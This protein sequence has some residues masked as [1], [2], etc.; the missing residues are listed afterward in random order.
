MKKSARA[1]FLVFL[2]SCGALALPQTGF[3]QEEG[4]RATLRERIKE[5]WLK[6]QQ[7]KPA[8]PETS[9][10]GEQISKPAGQLNIDRTRIF[11]TGMSNGGMMAYR[12]ACDMPDVF[13]AIASVAG[14]DST[15]AC[16]PRSPI[17]ILHIH[18]KD[19][20]HVLFGG[21]AGAGAF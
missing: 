14:T 3:A 6:R 12:L 2:L 21:G 15:T 17:A 18:A 10:A 20:D 11:A 5:R 8:T 19:D 7:E 9:A 16:N 4:K 13:K 1:V